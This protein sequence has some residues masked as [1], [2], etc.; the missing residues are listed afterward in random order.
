[1]GDAAVIP[2]S[3]TGRLRIPEKLSKVGVQEKSHE[4]CG[5]T[6]G[7]TRLVTSGIT[8]GSAQGKYQQPKP[9]A[10]VWRLQQPSLH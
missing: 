2:V 7:G 5:F 10:Q 9:W 4:L 3:Q 1:M 6:L 8:W